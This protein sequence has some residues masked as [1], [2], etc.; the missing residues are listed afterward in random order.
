MNKRLAPWPDFKGNPIYEGDL[1]EHPASDETG[2]VM[3]LDRHGLA[4]VDRWFVD[5]GDGG[6]PSR[7]G[8]QIGDK[9][10]AVVVPVNLGPDQRINTMKM[11]HLKK[12]LQELRG[13]LENAQLIIK[14]DASLPGVSIRTEGL[15]NGQMFSIESRWRNAQI[16]GEPDDLD[17][18]ALLQL[19]MREL[20]KAIQASS[21]KGHV[22][23]VE[24]TQQISR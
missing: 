8:L 4:E 2:V 1:I 23:P 16:E 9:G 13:L 3:Y 19:N 18:L 15:H 11:S 20:R 24:V 6:R 12:H 7:L 17:N 14:E 21:S 10:Q 5:Y 22:A